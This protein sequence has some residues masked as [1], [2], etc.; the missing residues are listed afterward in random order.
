MVYEVIICLIFEI[1]R[2][3][4]YEEELLDMEVKPDDIWVASYPKSGTTWSQEMV[5]LICNDL[6]FDRAKS[7]SLRTRFPFLEY[8]SSEFELCSPKMTTIYFQR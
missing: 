1:S 5:W 7:E 3:S 8:S 6:D 2:F 4:R